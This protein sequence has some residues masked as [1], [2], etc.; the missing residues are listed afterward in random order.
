MFP[1][2]CI[3]LRF[4][5]ELLKCQ[6]KASSSSDTGYTL[7]N[8]AYGT[9][10][11]SS[12]LTLFSERHIQDKV[13]DCLAAGEDYTVWGS[14]LGWLAFYGRLTYGLRT[15]GYEIL[16][17]LVELSSN[18]A[19]KY[20]LKDDSL[21]FEVRDVLETSLATTGILFLTSQCWDRALKSKVYSKVEKELPVGSIVI[22]YS[23]ELKEYLGDAVAK[24]VAPSSWNAEQAFH[25]FQ[26]QKKSEIQQ[27]TQ[28]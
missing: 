15:I 14:S 13:K 9:T 11:F 21:H 5:A 10:P 23:S 1:A 17:Y 18:L 19:E 28:S 22:D 20:D 26:K 24:C 8:F 4:Q 27:S 2:R 16:E 7:D 6:E 3:A 12:W 25:V